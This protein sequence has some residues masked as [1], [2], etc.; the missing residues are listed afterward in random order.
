MALR[1]IKVLEIA[2]LA[3]APFAGMVLADFGADVVRID[4]VG[5]NGEPVPSVDTLARGKRSMALDLK[6]D[7]GKN[8][9]KELVR[10]CDVLIEPFRPGVMER[11]GLGPEVLCKLNPKLIYARMT[12]FGQ[13]GDP[14]VE[15]AAGHDIDYIA[16]TGML[17]ALRRQ[18]ERPLPP[19]NLLGDFGGGGLVCALGILIA[20]I[21]RTKSGKGQV[22][23]AAMVDGASYVGSFVYRSNMLGAHKNDLDTVGTN[24]LDGGAPFYQTYTCKDGHH[25]AVGA[26]EPQFYK[27]LL[28]GL[29]LDPKRDNLPRQG[30]RSQWPALKLRF[31]DIFVTK[32]R[33]EWTEIFNGTDA[34]AFP[35]LSIDEAK[36]NKHNVLRGT[37]Q[38]SGDDP[39][40]LEPRPAP[41][42][43]RTPGA[44]P[45]KSPMSGESTAQVLKEYG[46]S[47]DRIKSALANRTASQSKL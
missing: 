9:L 1:G 41:V 45:R 36:K 27:E 25:F 46:F 13:G 37:F 21:E 29:G 12:G 30:D 11:L 6:S 14:K 24:I 8:I 31:A 33:D 15:K 19:I 42:L 38:P 34:C 44:S 5:K 2:G 43:S 22:I 47:D 20:I 28:R 17:S 23:D 18:G 3:P 26:I 35:V 16:L 40:A 32:T 39:S 7:E 10:K 4:R